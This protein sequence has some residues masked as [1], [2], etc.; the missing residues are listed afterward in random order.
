MRLHMD[1]K[2]V[3]NSKNIDVYFTENRKKICAKINRF[4]DIRKKY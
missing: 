1:F 3:V 4:V 2:S